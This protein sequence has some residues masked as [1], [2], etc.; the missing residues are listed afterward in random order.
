MGLGA[1]IISGFFTL[2]A[3]TAALIGTISF[4]NGQAA[5][6]ELAEHTLGAIQI[7]IQQNLDSFLSVPHAL[8]QI[9]ARAIQDGLV[10]PRDFPAMRARFFH[11]VQAFDRVMACAFGSQRGDFIGVGRR[12]DGVFDSAIADRSQDRDYRVYLLD[13]NGKPGE[14]VSVVND[15]EPHSRPWYQA[16]VKAGGPAWSPIYLWASRSNIGIS[17]VLP[18]FDH[19]GGLLGVQQSALAL[20]HISQFLEKIKVG[21][22]GLIFV[23]EPDGLLVAC[24]TPDL[25]VRRDP[26]RTDAPLERVSA[27]ES[28]NP[29][30][31]ATSH[32]LKEQYGD[33]SEIS[34]KQTL[35][36]ALDGKPYFLSVT[37]FKDDRSLA[38]VVA[39]AIPESDL[40]GS[41]E[42]NVCATV[43]V[44]LLAVAGATLIGIR[45]TRRITHPI[46]RLSEAAEGMSRGNWDKIEGDI[47]IREVGQLADAFNRMAEKLQEAFVTL[48][49]RVQERTRELAMANE[50][51]HAEIMERK[52]AESALRKSEAFLN[53]TGRMARVGGWELDPQTREMHWTE[54]TYAIHEV[55]PGYRPS[56]EEAVGFVH[57]QDRPR[58]VKAIGEALEQGEPYDMEIRLISAAGKHLWVRTTCEPQSED[59]RTVGL[60][61]TFQDISERK[62]AEEERLRLERR[63]LQAAKTESLGRM[64][65]AIA[66]H[67]N[68]LLGAV[69]GNLELALLDATLNSVIQS[70][71][72]DAMGAA[73][74]AAE[75]S[76]LLLAYLGQGIAAKQDLDLGSL[77]RDTLALVGASLPPRVS[78]RSRFPDQGPIV[79]A[80]AAQIQQ[81]LTNLMTNAAEAIGDKEGEVVVTVEVLPAP[82][83]RGFRVHPPDWEPRGPEYACL[84]VWDN[85]S[86]MDGETLNRLFDPFFSTRFSGRGLGLAVALGVVKAHDG[87][88]AVA[89][90]PG[91]GSHFRVFL[92]LSTQEAALPEE[93]RPKVFIPTEGPDLVLLVEDEPMLRGMAETMLKA[94]GYAVVAAADGVEAVEV[95]RKERDRIRCVL[96]DLTM[97]RMG[98]WECLAILRS[99][100]RDLPV[101]LTS[102]YDEARV[103]AADHADRPQ[104]FLQK[105]YRMEELRAA[106]RAV[107]VSGSNPDKEEG[108][109]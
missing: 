9:N 54:Q 61:G 41:A 88:I 33:L 4:R 56:L 36:A 42:S 32:Y 70:R 47:H 83:L 12:T 6:Q 102:G 63:L 2:I 66:H 34:G 104:V 96:L 38:W 98:G 92:P 65:G 91:Q 48:D 31:R 15:Y 21:Q 51:L 43:L 8:N 84:S 71:I 75:I 14:L 99:L 90:T 44:G 82:D 106:L 26:S 22:T 78:L 19:L 5:V 93:S 40:M 25:P 35:K 53:T 64:A 109:E 58:L 72:A 10:D 95:F 17:A 69:M 76:R 13:R 50:Q 57:P 101:I 80:D 73:G 74:R 68:N 89:S 107:W 81:V 23:M 39:I 30:I 59:G 85:G 52:A 46:R 11:Q 16:A 29:L 108:V 94:L 1:T 28:P 103:M 79:R 77:C 7:R 49:N 20:G 86:G 55:P 45:M 37:S 87:A 105:P 100:S 60:K 27:L 97:P 18:V 67:F 62:L 24:S 3:G